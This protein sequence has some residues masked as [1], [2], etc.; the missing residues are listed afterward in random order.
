[1]G[2]RRR[3]RLTWGAGIA[4]SAGVVGFVVWKPV[5]EE[6]NSGTADQTIR[7]E[8]PAESLSPQAGTPDAAVTL[9]L[10]AAESTPP[11]DRT[12][13]ALEHV[14][15][16]QAAEASRELLAAR[17]HYNL[18]LKQGLPAEADASVRQ[19]LTD[20]ADQ[21]IFSRRRVP[22]D[23]LTQSH[24][25]AGGETLAK[26]AKRYQVTTALLAR[27]NE[28]K[29]PNF[30]RKGQ[31]IKVI[32][33]PFRAV[34]DKGR[35]RISLYLQDVFVREYPVGLGRDDSTPTGDWR[36]RPGEKLENPTFYP[37]AS[38]GG[39]RIRADDPKNPLGEH[40]I[41]LEGL[42]GGAAGQESYGIHGTIEPETIGKSVSA[43]CIRMHNKDI[44]EVYAMLSEGHSHVLVRP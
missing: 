30:I 5:P 34:V 39:P 22:G 26:I 13:E 12:Q 14:T 21:T 35:H 18:A 15:K 19:R 25:I 3:R 40:W 36:V 41:G 32:R 8:A 1:M 24:S 44:A 4:I 11:P 38:I 42:T 27:I 23:P 6:G 37:P 2:R 29:N 16:G 20:L 9:S 31:R 33:G 43:G 28:I 7:V 17:E 10:S